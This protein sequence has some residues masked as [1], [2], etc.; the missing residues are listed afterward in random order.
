MGLLKNLQDKNNHAK[1]MMGEKYTNNC[2]IYNVVSELEPDF[3]NKYNE[4]VFEIEEVN[5]HLKTVEIII[6]E[7]PKGKNESGTNDNEVDEGKNNNFLKKSRQSVDKIL[8]KFDTEFK[9]AKVKKIV[10]RLGALLYQYSE[11]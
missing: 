2:K 9:G 8:R 11:I 5:K 10:E 1:A 6:R 4:L 7:G 3:Q